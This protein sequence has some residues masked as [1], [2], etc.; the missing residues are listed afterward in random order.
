MFPVG[1]ITRELPRPPQPQQPAESY[2]R[3]EYQGKMWSATGKFVVSNQV[4]LVP[5]GPKL[6]TGQALYAINGGDGGDSVLFVQSETSPDEFA[7]YRAEG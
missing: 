3:F 7:I 2:P 6:P 5:A 4:D 1:S